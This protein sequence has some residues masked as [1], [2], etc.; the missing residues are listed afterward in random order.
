MADF[1]RDRRR[2]KGSPYAFMKYDLPISISRKFDSQSRLTENNLIC[3]LKADAARPSWHRNGSALAH[4]LRSVS[5]AVVVQ[6][7]V[8]G[9]RLVRNMRMLSGNGLVDVGRPFGEHD[10]IGSD[11]SVTAVPH[12]RAPAQIDARGGE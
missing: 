5:A 10:V 7:E 1:P 4:D 9:T 6:S 12:F 2:L 11:E 3:R 8:A